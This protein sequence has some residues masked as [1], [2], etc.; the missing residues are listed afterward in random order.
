M[1][2]AVDI[3]IDAMGYN[4]AIRTD[5]M[6][7]WVQQQNE[8]NWAAVGGILHPPSVPPEVAARDPRYPLVSVAY[9]H[10][11]AG[12]QWWNQ[13]VRGGLAA[14]QR[15]LH[16]I[17]AIMNDYAE[18]S[19][20]HVHPDHQGH[21]LGERMLRRLLSTRPE[22]YVL[23][24]TPEVTGEDNR[25]WRLYRRL[26]FTDVLRQFRFPGDPRYFAILGA[27]LPLTATPPT[28]HHQSTPERNQR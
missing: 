7:A 21:G 8:P 10:S 17:H 18:L 5:R 15:S 4:P 20:I 28:T 22:R 27:E 26:G 2:E 3:Y 9:S 14:N 25:A 23:L 6:R 12:H 13:Q 24:S 16:E 19:E 1:K 11:G